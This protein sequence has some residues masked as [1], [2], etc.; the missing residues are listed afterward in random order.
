VSE[1]NI[2]V[3]VTDEEAREWMGNL[4][5]ADKAELKRR[6][7][8]R[9]AIELLQPQSEPEWSRLDDGDFLKERMRRHG[10]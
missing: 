10:F 9:R 6:A 8:E 5:D 7:L 3:Q 1:D 4:N 2:R